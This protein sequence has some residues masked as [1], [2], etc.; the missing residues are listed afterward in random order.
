MEDVLTK[1]VI[2]LVDSA[3]ARV[4]RQL[5]MWDDPVFGVPNELVRSALFNVRND[6]G[7]TAEREYLA[8]HKIVVYGAGSITYRGEELRQSDMD[9]WLQV[10]HLARLQ[11][12][13]EWVEFTPYALLKAIGRPTSKHY[14]TSLR[15]HLSRMQATSLTFYS[16]RIGRGINVSLIRKFE[17]QSDS[18]RLRLWRVWLEPEMRALF[19]ES[20]ISWLLQDQRKLLGPM[21]K[22]L[23]GFYASHAE[24]YP[25]K[26]ATLRQACGSMTKTVTDFRNRVLINALKELVEIGFLSKFWIDVVSDRVFVVRA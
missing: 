24:P 21:A 23:H 5:P 25:I 26:V 15:V 16:E 11:P 13:G 3:L 9:V 19:A 20:H 8:D 6:R 10:L 17:W 2:R 14:Y 1:K 22:W 7:K 4:P 18:E 12:L